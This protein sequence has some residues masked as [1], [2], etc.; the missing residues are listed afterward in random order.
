M[1]SSLLAAL[2]C[3]VPSNGT[4]MAQSPP[5]AYVAP[6][7]DAEIDAQC[8]HCGETWHLR[9]YADMPMRAVYRLSEGQTWEMQLLH[10]KHCERVALRI[11]FA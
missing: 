7:P 5:A 11:I 4:P 6:H 2:L 1:R 8:P 3:L 10:M 9:F